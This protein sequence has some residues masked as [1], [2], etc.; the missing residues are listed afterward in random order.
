MLFSNPDRIRE[1]IKAV[2]VEKK[3][4]RGISSDKPPRVTQAIFLQ[5]ISQ[6]VSFSLSLSLSSNHVFL[7]L[8]FIFNRT[9]KTS[10]RTGRLALIIHIPKAHLMTINTKIVAMESLP[11]FKPG[12]L[13]Q[14]GYLMMGSSIVLNTTTI[15]FPMMVLVLGI[16][17]S[18]FLVQVI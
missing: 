17:I 10:M 16:L 15:D 11:G 18:Q 6:Y 13:V 4:A 9:I 2:Y 3:F 12:G 14:R 5:I 7:I 1:F 8:L